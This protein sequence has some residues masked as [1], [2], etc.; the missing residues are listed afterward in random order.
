M[1]GPRPCERPDPPRPRLLEGAA[2]DA[3]EWPGPD[4]RHEPAARADLPPAGGPSCAGQAS[5][6]VAGPP[7]LAF[8][9]V[10]GSA[11]RPRLRPAAVQAGPQGG[12]AAAPLHAARPTAYLRQPDAPDGR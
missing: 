9:D 5:P 11:L 3:E 7:A 2:R 1:G 6:R 12:K 4:G 10:Y 8:C